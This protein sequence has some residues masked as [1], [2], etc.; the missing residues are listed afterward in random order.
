MA[1]VRP[2][3]LTAI[4][5]DASKQLRFKITDATDFDTNVDITI[6]AGTYYIAWDQQSDCLLYKI[7]SLAYAALDAL[8]DTGDGVDDYNDSSADGK[9][10]FGLDDTGKVWATVGN[11]LA[12]QIDWT[13]LDGVEI[14]GI[15][16]FTTA[17]ALT[18]TDGATATYQH[19]YG[20]Y[21]NQ[22]GGLQYEW[23][24]ADVTNAPQSVAENGAVR[25]QFVASRRTNS[26]T[27]QQVQK[28]R[29]FSR[30]VSYATAPVDP[31]ERNVPLECWWREARRGRQFRVYV[32]GRTPEGTDAA[33]Q[34]VLVG[35]V[36]A[37]STTTTI[38]DAGKSLSTDPQT[39]KGRVMHIRAWN[40]TVN[41]GD[42]MEDQ[43]F[44]ISS[45]TATVFTLAN[46]L[47]ARQHDATATQYYVL[48]QRY[49]TYVVDLAQMREFRPAEMQGG[50]ERFDITIPLLGYVP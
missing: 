26:L 35:G 18:I 42:V 5:L 6:P 10:H 28:A 38:T 44:Y 43:R 20:W 17:A 25:T 45:H 19:A 9:P 22:D 16:G 32:D 1:L 33:S 39:H 13:A 40:N 21:A 27:L 15:L 36:D 2:K 30:E 48:D 47:F 7:M 23:E 14:G 4:V 50:T 8:A 12:M 37:A 34:A 41:G 29:I 49:R 31:Y 46:S 3:I 24:D 11:G